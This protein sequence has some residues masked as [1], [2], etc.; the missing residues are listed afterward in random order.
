MTAKSR[1]KLSAVDKLVIED[2]M[3]IAALT[4]EPDAYSIRTVIRNVMLDLY[5]LRKQ[6]A[7]FESI[8]KLLNTADL[9]LSLSTLK[10]YY[11]RNLIDMK[12]QCEAHFIKVQKTIRK[13]DKG[14]AAIDRKEEMK[15]AQIANA[16]AV[17]SEINENLNRTR[18]ISRTEGQGTTFARGR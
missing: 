6:G 12:E 14:S 13:F 11:A 4:V 8:H 15:A 10:T 7:S 18:G 3:E 9:P 17:K 5:A 16:P 1:R 2:C